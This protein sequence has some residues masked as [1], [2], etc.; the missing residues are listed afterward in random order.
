MPMI[1]M[2]FNEPAFPDLAA[3]DPIMLETDCRASMLIGGM[4][5]G[6]SSVFM[7]FKMPDGKEA[8]WQTSLDML[9]AYVRACR[10]REEYVRSLA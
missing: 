4:S 9:E 2:D 6:K 8:V 5:S 7:V 3:K 1:D 10:A